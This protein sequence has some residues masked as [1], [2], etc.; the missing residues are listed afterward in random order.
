MI[1]DCFRFFNEDELVELRME[2]LKDKVDRF[3]VNEWAY[4]HNGHPIPQ[5]FLKLLE[6]RLSR[7]AHKI[8]YTYTTDPS[9]ESDAFERDAWHRERSL[10]PIRNCDD[11]DIV[12]MSDLDEIP[13]INDESIAICREHGLVHFKH[14]MFMYFLNL[15]KESGWYGTRMMTGKFVKP[16]HTRQ[17]RDSMKDVGVSY[18]GGWHWSFMGGHQK[19]VE[20]IETF[21]HQEFNNALVKSYLKKNV[22]ESRD[23]FFR[24]GNNKFEIWDLDSRFP[25]ELLKNKEYYEKLIKKVNT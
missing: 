12:L 15:H 8:D 22:L 20:K 1:Y 23:I 14:E 25:P 13:L 17:I 21:A 3:V 9:P 18:S 5:R 4:G 7:F 10:D 24:Y 11:D 16:V 19:V 6:G 2:I